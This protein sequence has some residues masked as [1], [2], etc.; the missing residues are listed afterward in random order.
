MGGR[1]RSWYDN[2]GGGKAITVQKGRTFSWFMHLSEQL[3]RTGEQIKAGQLIGKSGNTGSMTN[4]RHL[5][6]QV[7]QGGES[8]RYSTDPIPWLRK[9]DKN[10]WKEFT[11]REW[12]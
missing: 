3:R 12:F 10:W 8:N 11:W 4:Y 9:N 1:V 5:H 7:N 6:F 2:Y